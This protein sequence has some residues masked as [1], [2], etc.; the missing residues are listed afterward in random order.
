[1]RRLNKIYHKLIIENT[2]LTSPNGKK[3]TDAIKNRKPIS[4]YYNGPRSEVKAG[5]RIR[6]EPVALGLSK[7]GNIV[8]RGWVQP[9]SESK[10]GFQKHG[11]RL[12]RLDRLSNLI[13][14][15]D[16]Q[17]NM[18]REKYKEGDDDSMTVTYVTT[19]WGNNPPEVNQVEPVEPQNIE[20]PEDPQTPP[21][22]PTM[23]DEPET[24]PEIR[25][26][27]DG[28]EELPQ[29]KPDTK[30]DIVPGSPKRDIEVF[31]DLEK[32]TSDLEGKRIVDP[33]S[34]KKSMRDLYLKKVEDWKNNQRSLNMNT[35]PGE[36]TRRKFEKDS[37]IEIYKLLKDKNINVQAKTSLQESI[38]K[39]KSLMF[40]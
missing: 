7:G 15:E 9:P 30:P 19:S 18:K 33:D 20:T 23:G 38:E 37:E 32:Q 31:S 26:P 35:I 36:G 10:R 3:I 21:A 34:V 2:R 14:A 39:I 12:F 5:R 16:E 13:V 28:T 25:E 1:M 22:E 4:F 6:V 27:E 40:L 11:W 24:E 17:F 8:V 29:P